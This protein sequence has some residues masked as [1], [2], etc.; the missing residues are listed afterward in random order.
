MTTRKSRILR[1]SSFVEPKVLEDDEHAFVGHREQQQQQRLLMEYEAEGTCST[2]STTESCTDLTDCASPLIVTETNRKRMSP[3]SSRKP[4]RR[5]SSGLLLNRIPSVKKLMTMGGSGDQDALESGKA[6]EKKTKTKKKKKASSSRP[7]IKKAERRMSNQSS[8]SKSSN[9]SSTGFS[10]SYHSSNH[11][12]ASLSTDDDV[13]D[14]GVNNSNNSQDKDSQEQQRDVGVLA[15]DA[16]ESRS[17]AVTT[18]KKK[19]TQS[20]YPKQQQPSRRRIGRSKSAL[21][22]SSNDVSSA[23]ADLCMQRISLSGFARDKKKPASLSLSSHDDNSNTNNTAASRRTQKQS[24]SLRRER[25]RP[26]LERGQRALSRSL[27]DD[28]HGPRNSYSQQQHPQPYLPTSYVASPRAQQKQQQQPKA[29]GGGLLSPQDLLAQYDAILDEFDDS[30]R[31]QR[32]S[33]GA[34]VDNNDDEENGLVERTNVA[35]SLGDLQDSDEDDV[36]E[37]ARDD[38]NEQLQQ[39]PVTTAMSRSSDLTLDDDQAATSNN[40]NPAILQQDSPRPGESMAGIKEQLAGYKDILKEFNDSSVFDST[41][42][43]SIFASQTTA[44]A[45]WEI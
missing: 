39:Q 13:D 36:D 32:R 35:L 44:G 7:I 26:A 3:V 21:F 30:A 23:A 4:P 27:H 11:S 10:S 1:P 8:A 18:K 17:T 42:I 31:L 5:K 34:A 22:A 6:V 43:D 41:V 19:K 12:G 15:T 45:N 14:D 20:S 24:S 29:G 37:F 16:P 25:V 40:D 38:D 2:S 9:N 33:V 28:Y